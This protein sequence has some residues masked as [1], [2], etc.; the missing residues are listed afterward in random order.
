MKIGN[1]YRLMDGTQADPDD[2]AKGEDGIL[3][4]RSGVKVA[5]DGEGKP[6]TIAGGAATNEMAAHAGK[7][8]GEQ[9]PARSSDEGNV[10]RDPLLLQTDV[11]G[12]GDQQKTNDAALQPEADA[13]K[14][15]DGEQKPALEGDKTPAAPT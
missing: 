15:G 13:N 8:D 6:E 12:L 7:P 4:H 14:A 1:M 11:L 9:K 10:D 3:R 5:I 2:C